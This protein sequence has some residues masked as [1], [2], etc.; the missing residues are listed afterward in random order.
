MG[1]AR[2]TKPCRWRG[3]RL[4]HGGEFVCLCFAS[5]K[6]TEREFFVR[7]RTELSVK[8]ILT[9]NMYDTTHKTTPYGKLFIP[10]YSSTLGI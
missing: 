4:H 5:Q 9:N 6:P 8:T 3:K 10:R 2:L 1:Y 7:A